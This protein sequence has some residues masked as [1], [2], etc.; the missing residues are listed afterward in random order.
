MMSPI[1]AFL[2]LLFLTPLVFGLSFV[3]M[4][5]YGVIAERLSGRRSRASSEA[6]RAKREKPFVPPNDRV[7]PDGDETR[8][9]PF[10]F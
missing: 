8:E 4:F 9:G 10:E 6:A 5:V 7:S 1:D 3:G 2:D